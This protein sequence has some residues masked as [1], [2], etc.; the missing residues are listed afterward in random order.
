MAPSASDLLVFRLLARART[1]AVFRR[2][3][4]QFVPPPHLIT[5][6][7]FQMVTIGDDPVD[8]SLK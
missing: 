4:N 2:T 8:W 7:C 5:K 3:G 1:K 6:P